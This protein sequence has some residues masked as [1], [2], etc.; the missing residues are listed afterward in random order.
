MGLNSHI[1][2]LVSK[3]EAESILDFDTFFVLCLFRISLFDILCSG[4]EHQNDRRPG[5][6]SSSLNKNFILFRNTDL[7]TSVVPAQQLFSD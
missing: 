2:F 5:R 6:R 3:K 7:F 1:F 4:Q